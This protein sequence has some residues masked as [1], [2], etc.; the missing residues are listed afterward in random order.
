MLLGDLA[1]AIEQG[2]CRRPLWACCAG[3]MQ[4][5]TAPGLSDVAGLTFYAVLER[6]F[7]G[8]RDVDA[9]GDGSHAA[10]ALFDAATAYVNGAGAVADLPQQFGQKLIGLLSEDVRRLN[11]GQPVTGRVRFV[12]L[13]SRCQWLELTYSRSGHLPAWYNQR[14]TI[15]LNAT[16]DA[17]R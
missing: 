4:M 17:D 11:A 15:I 8:L 14:P 1:S 7:P 12:S 13:T 9:W 16:A 6:Y 2:E 5:W 10:G 3:P